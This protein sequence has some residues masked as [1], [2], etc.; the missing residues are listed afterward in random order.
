MAAGELAQKREYGS[1]KVITM[2][3]NMEQYKA[4][5]KPFEYGFKQVKQVVQAERAPIQADQEH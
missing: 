1:N 4:G 2:W 3:R 5:D